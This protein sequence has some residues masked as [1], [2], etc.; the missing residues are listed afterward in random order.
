[1]KLVSVRYK[2][3]S[4]KYVGKTYTYYCDLPVV[5]GDFIMAP[6]ARGDREA[7]V[8]EIDI[9]ESS[10]D[11]AIIPK[12]KVITTLVE[13]ANGAE[14]FQQHMVVSDGSPVTAKDNKKTG[15]ETQLMLIEN[16]DQLISVEQL[17]I[18]KNQ[19]T[20]L[21]PEIQKMVDDAL[22]LDVS[23]ETVGTIKKIRA[24]LNKRFNALEIRRAQIRDSVNGPYEAFMQVY[25]NCVTDLFKMADI[26]LGNGVKTV[27]NAA[28]LKKENEIKSYFSEYAASV[29]YPN[30][31]YERAE[32]NVTL[33]ASMKQLMDQARKFIDRVASE[34]SIIAEM[35]Y[36][37]EITVEYNKFLD[38]KSSIDIVKQRHKEIEE[39]N[40]RREEAAQR[41][42]DRK[43]AAA[44]VEAV[45]EK[46][47]E[48]EQAPIVAPVVE[49]EPVNAQKSDSELFAGF[50]QP[51]AI[52]NTKGT[53]TAV[54]TITDTPKRIQAL[55]QTLSFGGYE[56]GIAYSDNR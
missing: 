9:P 24:E 40:K 19:L 38:L 48:P 55:E 13:K 35:D 26:K 45:V 23:K 46:E 36:A 3:D 30:M 12:L 56:Y 4:E 17:P 32:I 49:F 50:G 21:K 39:A 42:A 33:S 11:K 22:A 25:K 43:I 20:L 27:E 31:A 14:D 1:M 2:N 34:L 53:V 10:I 16:E 41:E 47:S 37:D 6:T 51:C 52:S 7:M 15:A 54:L 44:K 29:G 8:A 28:K 18:I 5:V